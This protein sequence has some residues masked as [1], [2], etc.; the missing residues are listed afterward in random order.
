MSLI[1]YIPPK[2]TADE[3]A[4]QAFKVLADVEK[5]GGE[6]LYYCIQASN[7]LALAG[8]RALSPYNE[9]HP[10][11]SAEKVERL[12]EVL[13]KH[14]CCVLQQD[15]YGSAPDR[16]DF[17]IMNVDA[18][19]DTSNRYPITKNA[20][21]SPPTEPTWTD[22]QQWGIRMWIH[23]ANLLHDDELPKKWLE[24]WFTPHDIHFGMMLGYPGIAL[25]NRT[26]K[27]IGELDRNSD[28]AIVEIGIDNSG[29]YDGTN[30]CYDVYKNEIDS[31]EVKEHAALWRDTLQK[32][33][34]E[35]SD[36][37]LTGVSGFKEE[38]EKVVA[39]R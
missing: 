17:S 36:K 26:E 32:V 11:F 21:L 27:G 20:P 31:P 37:R 5:L 16:R 39:A 10:D 19:Q 38:E 30:V 2:I 13:K 6:Y 23:Y 35:Y 22:Y 24:N 18:L 25:Q 4:K 15:E 29:I 33:Y 28:M 8:L 12:N 9:F 14:N 1:E 3:A 7:I 34:D